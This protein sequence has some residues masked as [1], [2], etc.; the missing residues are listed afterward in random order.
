MKLEDLSKR[1]EMMIEVMGLFDKLD[2][3][4]NEN[5]TLRKKLGLGEEDDSPE[6][7]VA[8]T[9]VRKCYFGYKIYPLVTAK[10]VVFD[11]G[12]H[13]GELMP[14]KTWVGE[15]G[16]GD[17]IGYDKELLEDLSLE[18][19]KKYFN[20]ELKKVYDEKVE[21]YW[22]VMKTMKTKKEEEDK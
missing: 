4:E 10:G 8:Q 17:L 18:Q 15:L 11:S 14:Y 19:V 2:A 21:I 20:K 1:N 16:F 22:D 7:D 5:Q 12:D 6:E 3:L 9:A 13:I